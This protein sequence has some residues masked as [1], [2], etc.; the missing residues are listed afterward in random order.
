MSPVAAARAP[1]RI[2]RRHPTGV[3]A[4]GVVV[5]GEIGSE[6]SAPH[7]R[8]VD[9]HARRRE[10]RRRWLVRVW[11][12]GI[13]AAALAGVMVHAFMAEAQMRVGRVEQQTR[14]EQDRYEAVRLRMARL[15][16]PASIVSHAFRLG[17]VPAPT[18][19]VVSTPGSVGPRPQES[20][21]TE[22]WQTVKP[23]LGSSR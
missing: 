16:A 18:T 12:V 9:P 22:S 1:Q 17:L 8:L 15:A 7:L 20:T 11:A 13:V 23:S 6:D 10:R 14:I 19:R 4:P 3:R 5:P 21:S 2:P